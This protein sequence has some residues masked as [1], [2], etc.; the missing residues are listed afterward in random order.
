MFAKV[1][2]LAL[3]AVY[4]FPETNERL[5]TTERHGRKAQ[6]V[7]Y[8]FDADP[9]LIN[10]IIEE[11]DYGL[12]ERMNPNNEKGEQV[13]LIREIHNAKRTLPPLQE[14]YQTEYA[15]M[16]SQGAKALRQVV[17]EH[18]SGGVVNFDFANP[19]SS[20]LDL[21]S[22]RSEYAWYHGFRNITDK[23]HLEPEEVLGGA[24]Y[25]SIPK[26]STVKE[27]TEMLERIYMPYVKKHFT[28]VHTDFYWVIWM[29]TGE[30]S[31]GAM[32][33]DKKSPKVQ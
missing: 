1:S 10:Y 33:S 20:M 32:S 5:A 11:G 25:I 14:I 16:V 23:V 4:F 6:R 31:E 22:V 13:N 27:T 2:M 28:L 17:A 19:F 26:Y 7:A 29:R 21:P 24:K 3:L 15:Y 18:G 9:G 8:A 12:L 30:L